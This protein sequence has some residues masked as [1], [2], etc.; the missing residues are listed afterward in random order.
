MEKLKKR[1]EQN[2]Q[3]CWDLTVIIKNEEE[4]RKKIQEAKEINKRIVEMK[5]H[6][7]DDKESLKTFLKT[8]EKESRITELLYIYTYLKFDEDTSN[9]TS[10][11]H[12]LEM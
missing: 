3:D 11:S 8:S 4:Y 2:K 6:I 10:L 7:L 12:K 9:S 5:G 1:S